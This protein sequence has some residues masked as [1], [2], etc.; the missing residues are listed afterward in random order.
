MKANDRTQVTRLTEIARKSQPFLAGIFFP[1]LTP[2][3][4][5]FTVKIPAIVTDCANN[6][7]SFVGNH[8]SFPAS[9]GH[10]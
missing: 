1:A 2:N 10:F 9:H 7:T 5:K 8:T 6:H 3:L 4:P